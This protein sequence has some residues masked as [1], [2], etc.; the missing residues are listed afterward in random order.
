MVFSSLEFLGLFLPLFLLCYAAT[1][2]AWRNVTLLAFSWVFYGWW[3][4]SFLWVLVGVT[5]V[6][7]VAGLLLT[8]I[9]HQTL[10]KGL[11]ALSILSLAGMLAFFKYANLLV[12]SLIQ[13]LALAG[14]RDFHWERLLLPIGISFIVLQAI[15]Y[16]VDVYRRVVPVE[17]SFIDY[18][19]YQAMFS[20]LIAGP[21]VRYSHVA[22]E[23]H[24][25]S[26]ELANIAAGLRYFMIGLSMKVIVA[27]TIAP[28]ADV[29]FQQSTPTLLDAWLG[30]FAYGMQ[31]LFDFAGYSAMAIGIGCT[32]GFHFP[33]N[34]DAP[35]IS[36]SIQ[37]FWRRWHM[38]LGSWLRDYL[39]IPLGGSRV[40]PW[41]IYLN[42]L[43]I[44]A[45]SGLW[46]GA[47]SLNFLLWGI[48]HGIAMMI[49]RAWERHSGI[50][51]PAL[52]AWALTMLFVFSAWVLFRAPDLATAW[53]LY[54]GMAGLHGVGLSDDIAL[55]LRPIHLLTLMLACA[56]AAWP[57]WRSVGA[58]GWHRLNQLLYLWPIAG[59]LLSVALLASRGA[60]PFLYFQF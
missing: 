6:G 38:T 2:R 28:I 4:P 9:H 55:V 58:S 19:A 13:P 41:R 31:L 42:L 51:L 59:M 3:S 50:T 26:F 18:G 53:S 40:T 16:I 22:R 45:I 32:L 12:E 25:R 14:D 52:P 49:Q 23:L 39:Y 1:P 56:F 34:F 15:S 44:M 48:L 47:D 36:R 8:S 57:L 7:W 24:G 60:S 33:R 46:H 29:A 27:D 20:Q 43:I 35:Y 11:L 5:L 10:R 21:I 54:Q 30:T 37:E 17:R